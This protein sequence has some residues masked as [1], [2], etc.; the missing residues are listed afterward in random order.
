MLPIHLNVLEQLNG[1]H[2]R[3]SVPN[4]IFH[5][6]SGCGKGTIVNNFINLI[7]NNE[8]DLI[9]SLVMS[10]NCAHG[11]GIKF[12][13]EELKFFAKLNTKTI[14]FKTIILKN[15][16]KLT[17]D[18][19]SALRRCIESFSHTTR[20]FIIVEDKY[21][22]LK[23]ILSRF[24][25]IYIPYPEINNKQINLHSYINKCNFRNETICNERKQ[26]LIKTITNYKKNVTYE[27]TIMLS[28]KLYE[29]GYSSLDLLNYIETQSWIDITKRYELLVC[30]QKIK[31]EFRNEKLLFLFILNFI[32]IRSNFNLE[33]IPFM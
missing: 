21:K 18:A 7:Y 14:Y 27:N 20:F 15:A 8:N 30:I 26:W 19:Q 23:P 16:D 13:R 32:F 29:K 12:I 17:I 6:P 11:K 28:E 3:K 25:D 9:K 22:L 33:N 1:F 5:G 31:K 24:S 4:I 2:V 10:V